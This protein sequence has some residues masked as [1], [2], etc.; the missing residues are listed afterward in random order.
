MQV[1]SFLLAFVR[2]TPTQMKFRQRK[3]I[4]LK[5]IPSFSFKCT[6]Q[7]RLATELLRELFEDSCTIRCET[8]EM[9]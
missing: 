5:N 1:I 8:F 6:M 2:K 4:V 9:F 3:A 7:E